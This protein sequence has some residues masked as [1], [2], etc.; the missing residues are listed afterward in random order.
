VTDISE[1]GTEHPLGRNPA[2][3][4][5][6]QA[7]PP[8]QRAKPELRQPLPAAVAAPAGGLTIHRLDVQI[9]ERPR[10]EVI[11]PLPAPIAPA[12]SAWD[13]PDRRHQ[14]RVF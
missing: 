11:Q 12:G 7:P 8:F 1:T 6:R 4:P 9:V 10:T 3:T 5:S 14:G 2:S 13:L